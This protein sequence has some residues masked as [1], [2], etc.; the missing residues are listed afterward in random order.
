MDVLCPWTI[1]VIF[2]LTTTLLSSGVWIRVRVSY[3][4]VSGYNHICFFSN[5]SNSNVHR[6]SFP[7]SRI[8]IKC[9]ITYSALPTTFQS[10][11]K[12]RLC[13]ITI[14]VTVYETGMSVIILLILN[15][16]INPFLVVYVL[17]TWLAMQSKSKTTFFSELCVTCTIFLL[18][19]FC[20]GPWYSVC[21]ISVYRV[22]AGQNLAW[23]ILRI[24]IILKSQNYKC[25]FTSIMIV[26]WPHEPWN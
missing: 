8:L 25:L 19:K 22:L 20:T 10:L 13:T 2:I 24:F 11:L 15:H 4:Y 7:A 23:T 18:L 16:Q 17:Q 9:T 1:E 6:C 26:K 3:V 12:C 21:D 5:I 14:T